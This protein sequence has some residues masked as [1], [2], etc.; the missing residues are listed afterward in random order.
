[1][2]V[3]VVA[4]QPDQERALAHVHEMTREVAR[5]LA[6]VAFGLVAV[7]VAIYVTGESKGE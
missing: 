4:R 3:E 6:M 1:M 5:A 7:A 2:K